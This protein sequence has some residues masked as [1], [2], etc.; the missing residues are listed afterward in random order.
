MT[1]NDAL[2]IVR[3]ELDLRDAVKNAE[4]ALFDAIKD[5]S[6]LQLKTVGLLI[7]STQPPRSTPPEGDLGPQSGLIR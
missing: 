6:F 4:L 5:E 1:R 2:S 7:A 3:A